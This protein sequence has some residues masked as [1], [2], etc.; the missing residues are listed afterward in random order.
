M[1]FLQQ[2]LQSLDR[3]IGTYVLTKEA[4]EKGINLG[5]LFYNPEV[6]RGKK[7][8]AKELL[9]SLK[10]YENC[11]IDSFFEKSG[12]EN[13]L[14]IKGKIDEAYF[15]FI[16]SK[17]G[18]YISEIKSINSKYKVG[19]GDLLSFLNIIQKEVWP[20]AF[21]IAE[22]AQLKNIEK[23]DSDTPLN[24]V[25]LKLATYLLRVKMDQYTTDAIGW[26]YSATRWKFGTGVTFTYDRS[27]ADELESIVRKAL[28]RLNEV[29]NN[30]A[31]IYNTLIIIEQEEHNIRYANYKGSGR[32]TEY[33]KDAKE[34]LSAHEDYLTYI[35]AEEQRVKKQM[36]DAQVATFTAQADNAKLFF[37]YSDK[38]DIKVAPEFT[39]PKSRPKQKHKK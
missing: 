20:K 11:T 29:G 12:L 26:I 2:V 9:E 37:D 16:S 39:T 34:Q 10:P 7:Q 25:K 27:L 4:E 24:L 21:S 38:A 17:L 32:L 5:K 13:K 1:Y 8:K 15:G 19:K 35:K 23:T 36:R 28:N 18:D 31:E 3:M 6:T 14:E 33:L 30:V 22:F